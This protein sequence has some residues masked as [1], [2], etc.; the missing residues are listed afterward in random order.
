M[1]DGGMSDGGMPDGSMPDGSVVDSGTVAD[2]E[3]D[4]E[5]DGGDAQI[6]GALDGGMMMPEEGGCSCGVPEGSGPVS[7][8]AALLALAVL[9]G[10]R[11]RRR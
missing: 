7:P 2:A 1:S 11:R 5:T 9:F 10:L 4:A 8:G 3:A 6:D